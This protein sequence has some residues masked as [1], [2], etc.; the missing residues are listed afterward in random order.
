MI[1]KCVRT[2]GKSWRA[3]AAQNTIFETFH[4]LYCDSSQ[5]KHIGVFYQTCKLTLISAK[6]HVIGFN[7]SNLLNSHGRSFKTNQCSHT[8]EASLLASLTRPSA[9]LPQ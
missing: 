4:I 3:L 5:K 8:C 6:I 9:G 7:Q 1:W 2:A